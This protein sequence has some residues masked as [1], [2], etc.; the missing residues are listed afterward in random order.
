MKKALVFMA[1]AGVAVGAWFWLRPQAGDDATEAKLVATVET[2]PLRRQVIVQTLDLFGVVS[3]SPSGDQLVAA[4]FDCVIRAIHATT[5]AHVAAGELLLE[6]TP[7][8]DAELQ[9]ESARS[10]LALAA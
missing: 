2:T 6:I 9:L 3:S 5:G 4:P 1:I 8:P 10:A 7:S